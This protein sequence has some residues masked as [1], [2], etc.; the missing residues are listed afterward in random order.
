MITAKEARC[1]IE[2]GEYQKAKE[3]Y[4]FIEKQIQKAITEGKFSIT[5]EGSLIDT[6]K[7][8]L[9]DLGYKI[10]YGNQY[11]EHYVSIAW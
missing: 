11:N 6:N 8:I 9:K 10:D 4:E 5:I 7:S 2:S 1:I 3:Q